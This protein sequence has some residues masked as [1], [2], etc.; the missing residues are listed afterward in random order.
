MKIRRDK[1]EKV[2]EEKNDKRERDEEL[3]RRLC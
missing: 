3:D 2:I 1:R